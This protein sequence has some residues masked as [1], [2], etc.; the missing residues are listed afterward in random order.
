MGAFL[1][2]ATEARNISE[3]HPG[4]NIRLMTLEANYRVPF[5]RDLLLFFNVCSADKKS[6]HYL[7]GGPKSKPGDSC[8]VVTG[9]AA[10]S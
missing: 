3:V 6:F 2:I 10:E 8:A 9:G 4:L 7:L 1:T 5:W